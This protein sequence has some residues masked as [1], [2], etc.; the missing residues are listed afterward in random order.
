MKEIE[1]KTNKGIV[2]G[3]CTTLKEM[4]DKLAKLYRDGRFVSMYLLIDEVDAF[5]SAI[6]DEKYMTI[7]PLN[8][9]R[10][11]S[12]NNFKFVIAGTHNVCRAKNATAENGIF[13]QMGTPLC[14]KP[15]S[16]MDALK[17]LSRP[18][19]YLGFRSGKRIWKRF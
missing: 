15:L 8:D 12:K 16:P 1:K 19:S 17:L 14:I 2:L 13:G 9:L 7:Q 4:C 3:A 10:R 18:L 6:A 5:L 11:E